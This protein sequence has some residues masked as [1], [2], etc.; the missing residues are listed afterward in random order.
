[1]T[2]A[3]IDGALANQ[4]DAIKAIEKAIQIVEA[5]GAFCE[6]RKATEVA[7]VKL[8]LAQGDVQAANHW[9]AA[10]DGCLA[11]DDQFGF[12]NELIL[13]ARARV[14]MAQNRF[15]EAVGLLS[16]LEEYAL[17]SGRMGRVIEIFLLEALI[18]QEM[19]NLEQA[20]IVLTKCLTLAEPEGYMRIF[21]DEGEAVCKL[22][23]QLSLLELTNQLDDYVNRILEAG[24]SM[25]RTSV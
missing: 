11:S 1:M 9:I 10:Q 24:V 15:N 21:L 6:A 2:L 19:G 18:M 14:L 20:L 13:I 3:R 5:S 4:G 22:L 7:Q 17:S 16:H 12:Q 25:P 8:W 23:R